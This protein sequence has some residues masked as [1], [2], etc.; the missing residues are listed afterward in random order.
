M[1]APNL[2]TLIIFTYLFLS[3]FFPNLTSAQVPD[4][5]KATTGSGLYKDRIFWLN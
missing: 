3:S 4:A 2:K 1:K 5:G